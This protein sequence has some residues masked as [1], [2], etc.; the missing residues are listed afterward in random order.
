MA[1][2][3]VGRPAFAKGFHDKAAKSKNSGWDLRESALAART[4]DGSKKIQELPT[5]RGV[6]LIGKTGEEL[7]ESFGPSMLR[8]VQQIGLEPV[9]LALFDSHVSVTSAVAHAVPAVL[10][11]DMPNI[12][13]AS[14]FELKERMPSVRS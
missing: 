7:A 3:A 2:P 5:Y 6:R 14:G 1:L 9:V 13:N 10:D 12:A 11:G 8:K 4:I